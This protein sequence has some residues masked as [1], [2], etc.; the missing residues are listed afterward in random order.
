VSFVCLLLVKVP[1]FVTGRFV[2]LRL[3]KKNE[4]KI[5]TER[6]KDRKT[7]KRQNDRKKE[8]QKHKKTK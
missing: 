6:K 8:R 5:K 3:C 7:E 4:T 2:D 1:F